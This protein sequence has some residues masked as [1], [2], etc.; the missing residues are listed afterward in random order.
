VSNH[1]RGSSSKISLQLS[2]ACNQA[3][4]TTRQQCQQGQPF[5]KQVAA[6]SNARQF[7]ASNSF[8]AITLMTDHLW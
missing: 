6:H 8:T 4:A 2:L 3:A 5:D 1:R 7:A